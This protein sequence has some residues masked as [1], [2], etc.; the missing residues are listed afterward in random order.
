MP[1]LTPRAFKGLARKGE[2]PGDVRL[3]KLYT[4]QAEA[5]EGERRLRFTISTAAVDREY[6]TVA[7]DGWDLDE[8]QRNPVVLWAH[9]GYS[10]PVGRGMD[11]AVE[12]GALKATV[13]FVPADVPVAGPMAEA[14]YQLCLRGYLQATSVGFMP[15]DWVIPQGESAR[16]DDW[17]PGVDFVKQ[18]L[19]EFSIVTIPCNP[20]ALLDP[21]AQT[22]GAAVVPDVVDPAIA[23][24]AARIEAFKASRARL[25][26]A[27]DLLASV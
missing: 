17:F 16:G 8:Y 25:R 24:A 7:I 11:L 18:R 14:V 4:G 23:Q 22:P 10:L 9:D 13:D 2:R 6:D 5:V 12:G 19:L 3:Q 20:E 27:H 1:I 15:L 21:A 26:R